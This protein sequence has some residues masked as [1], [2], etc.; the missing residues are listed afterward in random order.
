M[1]ML[2]PINYQYV[3]ICK[4]SERLQWGWNMQKLLKDAVILQYV[5]TPKD[6]SEVIICKYSQ[7]LWWG[8]NFVIVSGWYHEFRN[9]HSVIYHIVH[10]IWKNVRL[11]IYLLFNPQNAGNA[12][13]LYFRK[14]KTHRILTNWNSHKTP[15]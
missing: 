10:S 2:Q 4:L 11:G 12:L 3:T 8:W 15:I 6:C 1:E 14:R 7:R 5:N 13:K 9:V